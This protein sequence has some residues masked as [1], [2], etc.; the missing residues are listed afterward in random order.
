LLA[1]FLRLRRATALQFVCLL[2]LIRWVW[3]FLSLMLITLAA[4]LLAVGNSFQPT[5]STYSYY[6]S[7]STMTTGNQGAYVAYVACGVVILLSGGCRVAL[8][9][10]S[11]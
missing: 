6:G 4:I 5:T 7:S 3:L 2:R 9:S 11:E 8:R 10:N 1:A